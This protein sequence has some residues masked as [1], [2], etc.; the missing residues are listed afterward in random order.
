M[1]TL[2]KILIVP[3]IALG[4]ILSGM[5]YDAMAATKT[6]KNGMCKVTKV[7]YKT[8]H[9]TVKSYKHHKKLGY[10]CGCCRYW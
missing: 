6:C 10:K 7:T 8:H 2:S 9:K 1:K 3:S 4:L 5:S